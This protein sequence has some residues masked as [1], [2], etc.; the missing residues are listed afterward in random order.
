LDKKMF[1]LTSQ[2]CWKREGKKQNHT[3]SILLL[4]LNIV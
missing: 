1:I 2:D 4:K 3:S